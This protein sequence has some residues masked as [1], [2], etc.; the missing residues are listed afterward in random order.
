MLKCRSIYMFLK[1]HILCETIFK[2]KCAFIN[3][4]TYFLFE[5][6]KKIC[7]SLPDSTL[8]NLHLNIPNSFDWAHTKYTTAYKI[9]PTVL[10]TLEKGF[11]CRVFK[12]V[13]LNQ[14]SLNDV[15]SSPDRGFGL[16]N[17]RELSS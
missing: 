5:N 14:W 2:K 3:Y 8:L 11:F 10:D 13:N 15:G 4:C 16:F 7:H 9:R 6:L 1:P 17:I 12:V